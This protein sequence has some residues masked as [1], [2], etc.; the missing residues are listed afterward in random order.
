MNIDFH[1]HSTASDG[2]LSP[3]D[4]MDRCVQRGLHCVALTDHDT[5]QGY[6]QAKEHLDKNDSPLKLLCGVELSAKWSKG[7]VHI[8]GL[9]IDP[10]NAVLKDGLLRLQEIRLDRIARIAQRLDKIGIT[11]VQEHIDTHCIGVQAGRPHI[12]QFL[13]ETGVVKTEQD[14][15]KRYLGK[16]KLGDISHCW[17]DLEEVVAWI[18]AAGG[19]AVLAHPLHYKLSRTQL[20]C[21]FERFAGCGGA[22]VEVLT[23]H[24]QAGTEQQLATLVEQHNLYASMGSDFHTPENK[25]KEVGRM[26]PLPK[27]SRPVWELFAE[28]L[29]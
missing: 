15:F 14:A 16:G 2:A 9:N 25:W 8:V 28:Q 24:Q 17:P 20:K 4:L 29:R 6:W 19:V 7:S 22:A 5:L 21:L 27:Q 26:L 3:A 11:G 18:L 12:A 13:L 10:Q 1:M 23:G